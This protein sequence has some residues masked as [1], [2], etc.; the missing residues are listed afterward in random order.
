MASIHAKS[1]ELFETLNWHIATT[2]SSSFVNNFGWA[3]LNRWKQPVTASPPFGC[4]FLREFLASALRRR[5][6]PNR[7]LG[8][9]IQIGGSENM[10][11]QSHSRYVGTHDSKNGDHW[12]KSGLN[13]VAHHSRSR[14]KTPAKTLLGVRG[15][16]NAEFDYDL[17]PDQWETLK[18]IRVPASSGR[19]LNRFVIENLVALQLAEMNEGQAAITPK[20]RSVLLRGSPLLWDVAA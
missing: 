7:K 13:V 5:T 16:M 20:G 11:Q 18:A 4:G 19:A 15:S 9:T 1:N 14:C 12:S 2:R 17:T 10:A 8:W 6:L 3:V